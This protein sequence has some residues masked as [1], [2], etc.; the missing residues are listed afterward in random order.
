LIYLTLTALSLVLAITVNS[1]SVYLHRRWRIYDGFENG[2]LVHGLVITPFWLTFV[3]LISGLNQA[4]GI[5]MPEYPSVGYLLIVI[6]TSLFVVSIR[7]IGSGALVNAN[8]FQ[9]SRVKPISTGV[10][11]FLKNPI[12]DS[13]SL[14]FMG[15][16]FALSNAAFFVIAGV[17]FIGLN[18]IESK[19][20]R[21]G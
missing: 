14:L 2:L 12:Y 5:D 9:K 20:E 11:K 13:Y 3:L 19:I 17:S 16:G 21:M 10:Y 15:L 18:I 7:Q 4:Y 6:A 8:F 1:A